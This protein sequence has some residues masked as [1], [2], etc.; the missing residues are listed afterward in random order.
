MTN[1]RPF[2]EALAAE[3]LFFEPV[4]PPSRIQVH[5][6]EERLAALVRLVREVPRV[7]AIDVPELVDEN[8]EGKPHYRSADVRAFAR[9]LEERSGR[10]AVVNKVV[11]Y[12]AAEHGVDRWAEETVGLGLRY[13]VLVGGASRYIPYPG[14]SVVDADRVCRPIFRRVG[15]AVGNIA[16]P[17]RTGEAHRMLSKTRVGATFFTTQIVFDSEQVLPM[18]RQYDLLCRQAALPPATVLLSF[19]PIADED[20]IEFVRWLGADLSDAAER[21]ILE[22]DDAETVRRSEERALEVWSAVREGVAREQVEVPLGVNVEQVSARHLEPAGHL[23]HEFAR[24]LSSANRPVPAAVGP[25]R[26]P[27]RP[28]P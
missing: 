5:R 17:P 18:L 4:P 15:G 11:A 10:P 13:A 21:A 14:P 2:E 22:G 1:S 6:L 8:H 23:L 20:D 16:I 12:L 27:D 9:A 19:A 7:D 25:E 26:S 28:R 24:R 3:P